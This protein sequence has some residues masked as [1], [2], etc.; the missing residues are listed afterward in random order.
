MTYE[1][2]KQAYITRSFPSTPESFVPPIPPQVCDPAV[3]SAAMQ[4][5]RALT[6]ED[7]NQISLQDVQQFR[8]LKYS[9]TLHRGDIVANLFH[10]GQHLNSLYEKLGQEKFLS[11]YDKH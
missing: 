5:P 6:A 8:D 2:A 3:S 11:L 1:Q 10:R 7:Y 9:D 4:A